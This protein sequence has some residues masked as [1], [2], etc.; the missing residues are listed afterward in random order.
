MHADRLVAMIDE[1]IA[2][3]EGATPPRTDP[4]QTAAA[5]APTRP[6]QR[7]RVRGRAAAVAAEAAAAAAPSSLGEVAS[8]AREREGREAR[9]AAGP[10]GTGGGDDARPPGEPRARPNREARRPEARRSAATRMRQEERAPLRPV[11]MAARPARERRP[12][13]Q[14]RREQPP[15]VAGLEEDVPDLQP[16]DIPSGFTCP[17]TLSLMRDPV[18]TVDGHTYERAAIQKWFDAHPPTRICSPATGKKLR[19]KN[20][21][22]NHALRKAIEEFVERCEPARATLSLRYCAPFRESARLPPPRSTPHPPSPSRS[23]RQSG[24][25]A[26]H[27]AGGGDTVGRRVRCHGRLEASHDVLPASFGRAH[28]SFGHCQ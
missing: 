6:L 7:G 15:A 13:P 10:D 22:P 11:R 2:T 5:A 27:S 23:H 21:K 28:A 16:D 18:V 25:K 24:D 20:L 17:I 12:L 8:L 3:R 14:S 26:P 19:S 9:T 4:G 1:A